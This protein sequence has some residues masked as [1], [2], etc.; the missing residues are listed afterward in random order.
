MIEVIEGHGLGSGKSYY[1]LTRLF[2]HFC[3]GGTAY[4]TDTFKIKWPEL[5]GEAEKRLGLV[6][7]DE[8]LHCIPQST[9]LELFA[10]TVGGD[11]DLSVVIVLDEIQ[12]SLNARDWNDNR[13]R[14]LFDWCCQSRHDNNDIWVISQSQYNIDKQMR[15]LAT[16]TRKVRNTNNWSSNIITKFLK[17]IKLV[18][19]GWHA[20][21]YF[22][23]RTYDSDG[24]TE[25]GKALWLEHD[26]GLFNC[27]VSRSMKGLRKRAGVAVGRLKLDKVQ[28]KRP[29]VRWVAGMTCLGLMVTG[30]TVAK[31]HFWPGANAEKVDRPQASAASAK[32]APSVAGEKPKP[33]VETRVEGFRALYGSRWLVTD[34]RAYV[35]GAMC[36]IGMVEGILNGVVSVRALDGSKIYVVS[37]LNGGKSED[38]DPGKKVIRELDVRDLAG[39][40]GEPMDDRNYEGKFVL[41]H[42]SALTESRWG[43][44]GQAAT[45]PEIGQAATSHFGSAAPFAAPGLPVPVGSPH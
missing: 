38:A 11:D 5:K 39:K 4:V 13:K 41:A 17:V 37:A 42:D 33:G 25:I 30:C 14:S 10:H 12:S 20:G 23:V 32:A 3:G 24:K 40:R 31:R 21:A 43:Q 9:I 18:T 35:V 29:W 26:R 34:K 15:R 19:F 1:V 16:F 8:Q 2:D 22:V 36:E 27:Y 45:G 28:S 6:L 44:E 7:Q